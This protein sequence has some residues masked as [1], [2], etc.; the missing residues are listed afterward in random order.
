MAVAITFALT[1][2]AILMTDGRRTNLQDDSII[3]GAGGK[4]SWPDSIDISRHLR[5]GNQVLDSLWSRRKN[6][7]LDN[8]PRIFL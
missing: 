5:I 1:D 4:D 3:T 6:R 7:V 2:G 8:S